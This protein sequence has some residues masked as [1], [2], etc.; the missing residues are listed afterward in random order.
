MNGRSTATPTLTIST[1]AGLMAAAFGAFSAD[2][3][4]SEMANGIQNA[5]AEAATVWRSENDFAKGKE[6]SA[7]SSNINYPVTETWD[8]SK[9]KGELKS[10]ILKKASMQKNFTAKDAERLAMLQ[11][12]RRETLPQAMSYE[13]F[14]REHDRREELMKLTGALMAY[15]RKYGALANG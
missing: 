8:D 1:G 9:H 3:F 13:E 15:E 10:L 4:A 6:Q 5:A 12:M 14:M 11:Q 7:S 2:G